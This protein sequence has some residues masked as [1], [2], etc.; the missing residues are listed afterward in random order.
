MR[1]L[2]DDLAFIAPDGAR[3]WRATLDRPRQS[4]FR[5]SLW[6]VGGGPLQVVSADRKVP[7]AWVED[8][9]SGWLEQ[10]HPDLPLPCAPRRLS[11]A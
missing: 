4:H 8:P 9:W 6:H 2:G 10:R 5:L 7:Y 11:H 3:R 1:L